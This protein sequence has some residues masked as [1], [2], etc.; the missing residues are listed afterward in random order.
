MLLKLK[1]AL[2]V[3]GLS[4]SLGNVA[5]AQTLTTGCWDINAHGYNSLL[6]ENSPLCIT[7]IDQ[8]GNFSG[9]K[10]T[11]TFIGFWNENAKQITFLTW[12]TASPTNQALYQ[13]YTGRWIYDDHDNPYGLK[14]M[15]GT[16]TAFRGSGATPLQSEFGWTATRY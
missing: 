7:W 1:H 10:G 6:G 3:L 15:T 2:V 11:S 12:P 16:F 14:R 8:A 4:L 13:F 5:H 9:V